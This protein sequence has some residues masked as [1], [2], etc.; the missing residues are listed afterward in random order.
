MQQFQP[1]FFVAHAGFAYDYRVMAPSAGA[2]QF[3]PLKVYIKGIWQYRA[4]WASGISTKMNI[5]KNYIADPESCIK[6]V[7][8]GLEKLSKGL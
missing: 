8:F 1:F 2:S 6:M 4:S 5:G 3:Q 7:D